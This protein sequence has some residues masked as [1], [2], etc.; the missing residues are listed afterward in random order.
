MQ[1]IRIIK[2][3]LKKSI[4]QDSF[5][6]EINILKNIRHPSI[7]IIYDVEE[8]DS[9]YYIIEEYIE[10][11]TLFQYVTKRG[12]LSQEEA[13]RI[14]VQICE[15]MS[16][17]HCQ[18]PIP[19]LFLDVHPKNI[20]IKNDKIY[21]VDF[22]S[23]F[24]A[25]ETEKRRYLMGT[26]GYAAPE[27]YRY[28]ALDE[29]TDIY[30]IGAVLYFMVTGTSCNEGSTLS[31]KFPN[32]ISG[33]YRIIVSQC[34]S[35]DINER[36]KSVYIIEKN[37]EQLIK[38]D[39]TYVDFDRPRIISVAGTQSRIGATHVGISLASYI[40]AKGYKVIYEE[41]NESNHVRMIAGR[42][43]LK[44]ENGFF[45]KGNLLLKPT[46]GP[47][48]QLDMECDYIVRDYGCQYEDIDTDELILLAGTKEWEID[49][50]IRV[51]NAFL[52]DENIS[53]KLHILCNMSQEEKNGELWKTIGSVGM[54]VPYL[55]DIF[56]A[57]DTTEIFFEELFSTLITKSKGGRFYKK[58]TRL[59][60]RFAKGTGN[61]RYRNNGRS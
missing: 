37:L 60:G 10:G 3:I 19:I 56:Y 51:C 44:Y 12:V 28:D 47:Q 26:I 30:G 57:Y 50:S 8:D 53:K 40:A 2:K 29:R 17:L 45:Y 36:F 13:V 9:S 34:L 6:S 27:Q 61:N 42:R 39:N 48:V 18:K 25:D 20:L 7:P 31:L 5:Y 58:K 54:N 4:H 11:E 21:L 35:Q 52:E 46:Y 55:N 43:K 49:N 16:F 14:G 1:A 15:I 32:N 23:S 41:I 33:K 22:G 38:F 59:F 24:F